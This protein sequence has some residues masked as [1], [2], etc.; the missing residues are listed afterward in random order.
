MATK[1]SYICCTPTQT[2]GDG[3]DGNGRGGDNDGD[4]GHSNRISKSYHRI[5]RSNGSERGK[6]KLRQVAMLL[7]V[8][9]IQIYLLVQPVKKRLGKVCLRGQWPDSR[10]GLAQDYSLLRVVVE[11]LLS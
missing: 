3:G 11:R 10:P 7:D 6:G 2:G 8:D 9:G 4:G 1:G 5:F